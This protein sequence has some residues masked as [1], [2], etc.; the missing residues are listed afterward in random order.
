M[1]VTSACRSGVDGTRRD[2]PGN[3]PLAPGVPDKV[4]QA[5]LRHL[6]VNDTPGCYVK[7]QT[8]DVVAAMGK[9]EEEIATHS[10]GDTKCTPNPTEPASTLSL[11]G[12][13]SRTN[14]SA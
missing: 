1:N 8:R 6:N 9:F 3:K 14:I 7:P 4:I 12:P 10:F 13:T 2:G 5:I 11:T